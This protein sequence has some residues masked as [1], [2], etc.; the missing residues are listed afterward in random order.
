MPP[1]QALACLCRSGTASVRMRSRRCRCRRRAAEDAGTCA[2]T[3]RFRCNCRQV[4]P[5]TLSARGTASILFHFNRSHT[6]QYPRRPR[7]SRRCRMRRQ[8]PVK[9]IPSER[10]RTPAGGRSPPRLF[11]W[12]GYGA[13]GFGR[14]LRLG[15]R[16]GGE[17]AERLRRRTPQRTRGRRRCCCTQA[18]SECVRGRARRSRGC[19]KHPGRPPVSVLNRCQKGIACWLRY[20]RGSTTHHER[21]G[22][23]LAHSDCVDGREGVHETDAAGGGR[24]RL[25]VNRQRARRNGAAS[26]A[27][28]AHD[29]AC[30]SRD[31][32]AG[33]NAAAAGTQ[34]KCDGDGGA[35]LGGAHGV[36]GRRVGKRHET[37]VPVVTTS[38]R[39]NGAQEQAARDAGHRV[40]DV[41]GQARDTSHPARCGVG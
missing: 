35:W 34:D 19:Q 39:R 10:R 9:I 5:Q 32:A 22:R 2:G 12:A 17:K 7:P 25:H 8:G 13:A 29:N 14:V 11:Q 23:A 1:R 33:L 4:S 20:R 37:H 38:A 6:S 26:D 30:S 27:R 16:R 21:K 15:G 24:G 18:C 36:R 31:K 41:A 28:L 40:R 3:V